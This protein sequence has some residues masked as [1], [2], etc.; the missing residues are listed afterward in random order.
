MIMVSSAPLATAIRATS[1]NT[2]AG[3]DPSA[4]TTS[5]SGPVDPASVCGSTTATA[6]TPTAT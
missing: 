5:S 1:E 2:Q 3:T 6:A 4:S